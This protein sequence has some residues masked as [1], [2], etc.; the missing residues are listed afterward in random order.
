MLLRELS[1]HLA[2][3]VSIN[4]LRPS[5]YGYLVHATIHLAIDFPTRNRCAPIGF[6]R[7]R[8]KWSK[9]RSKTTTR[10]RTKKCDRLTGEESHQTAC[11]AAVNV[12]VRKHQKAVR[13]GM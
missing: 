6:Q 10:M 3:I 11:H 2:R 8:V 9:S 1:K 13:G 5:A 12:S 4:F 7:G